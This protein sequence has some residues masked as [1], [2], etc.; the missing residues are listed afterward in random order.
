[1][2][3]TATPTTS[4]GTPRSP[5]SCRRSTR[6]PVRLCRPRPRRVRGD[7]LRPTLTVSRDHQLRCPKR[8]ITV[9]P[10]PDVSVV[11]SEIGA[12]EA[13]PSTPLTRGDGSGVRRLAG[14]VTCDPASKT[15]TS[16]DM[17]SIAPMKPSSR[18][19][20]RV[21]TNRSRK[22]RRPTAAANKPNLSLDQP[23][24]VS[25]VT[26]EYVARPDGGCPHRA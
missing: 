18:V 19:E 4:T 12:A 21:L 25:Q 8:S 1:M 6:P 20:L 16:A 13:T 15:R 24:S 2:A 26:Y 22:K 17:F 9:R 3:L 10:S 14:I 11:S 23:H 7:G 5:P